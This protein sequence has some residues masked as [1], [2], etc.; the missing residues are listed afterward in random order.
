MREPRDGK[1]S[2]VRP[3]REVAVRRRAMTIITAV[4]IATP[5]VV[6]SDV[7][8]PAL[9]AGPMKLFTEQLTIPTRVDLRDGGGAAL[10]MRSGRHRFSESMPATKTF[11]YEVPDEHEGGVFGGP[12][13]EASKG[14][15]VTIKVTNELGPHPLAGLIDRNIMGVDAGDAI[16]PRGTVHLHGAHN[17]TRYDGEPE[18]T[19]KPGQSFTYQY[20][21]D[22]DAAGLWYHDHSLGLTRLQVTAG[23]VGQYWLRDSFDTG[24]A[25]N[26]LGLPAGKYEI[27]LTMQD[28][29]FNPD[30][31]FA[32]PVGAFAGLSNPAGYPDSWAPESFGDVSV[33]NGK[34]F[35]NLDVARGLYRFRVVNASN[36]RF[37]NLRFNVP[38]PLYEIGSDGGLLNAPVPL[39]TLLLAPAERADLLVDFSALA[40]GT[41][42]E[43][44]NDAV[45]PFPAGAVLAADGGNPLPRLMQF[46]VTNKAGFS[47]ALPTSLRGGQHQPAP[48]PVLTATKTRTVMLNEIEDPAQPVHVM[49][50]NLF[51]GDPKMMGMARMDKQEA[52]ALN[53]VEEWDIVNTTGDAHPIHLHLTQFRL[54]NRQP[55]NEDAYIASINTGLPGSGLSGAGL[56]EAVAAGLGPWPAASPDAY[57]SGNVELPAGPESGWKDTIVAPPGYVTRIVVPFGGTAAGI[58]APFVGDA[59]S[60]ASQRF[61][62]TYVF[63]CHILEHEDNDMMSPYTITA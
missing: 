43:L 19:Y 39:T 25:N 61:T 49:L 40:A 62:G 59:P 16:A 21:N 38:V 26:P 23:L 22:Q 36:A 13:I 28:R 12:T 63:H 2:K 14:K 60:A 35:P 52:P 15:P 46:T 31:S 53:S 34:A 6:G 33:V 41:R 45:A 20:G 24:R 18:S 48:L 56:P 51:Y 50:N 10:A 17:E 44:T 42:L 29:S 54:L 9:A 57:L 3:R 7:A 11:G 27:P 4:A 58:P 37:Y 47:G 1:H 30:G 32:Y 8:R 55:F 5:L